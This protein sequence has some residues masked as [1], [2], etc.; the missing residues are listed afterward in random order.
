MLLRQAQERKPLSQAM[1]AGARG[2]EGGGEGLSLW[3]CPRSQRRS[4]LEKTQICM[5]RGSYDAGR[6]RQI[7]RV[8]VKHNVLRGLA[9]TLYSR[10]SMKLFE[11]L[12]FSKTCRIIGA[13]RF[14]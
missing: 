1:E 9:D 4:R 11:D 12:G 3:R 6:E 2:R 5:S 7:E 8:C 10:A 13:V 14:L